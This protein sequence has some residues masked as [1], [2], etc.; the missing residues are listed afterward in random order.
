MFYV[1]Q[2]NLPINPA[3]PEVKKKALRALLWLGIVSI[4]ML[5][6]GLT[7]AYIVRQGEGKWVEFALPQLFKISSLIIILSSIS[8]QWGLV[9]IKKNNSARLKVAMFITLILGIGFII[10]QYYAWS[11]LYH[12]GIVFT[13]RIQDIKTDFKYIPSGNETA[14]DAAD[15][16][17]V[18]GSFLYVLTGLHVAHLLVGVIALIVVFSR[19]LIGKYSIVNY[20]GV[21][22]CAIYWHFL[23]GLWLYL[24]FFLLYIR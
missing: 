24:F 19:A 4:A 14:A 20:N 7:S 18:A 3:E 16:G 22:M 1:Q 17:N 13:G 10:S 5:F 21:K 2:A 11:E 15:A 23:G 8:I 9:S 6:A 12:N